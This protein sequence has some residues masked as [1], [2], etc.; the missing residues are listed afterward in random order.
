MQ[1]AG[2]KGA[3]APRVAGSPLAVIEA[4]LAPV[5]GRRL[6]DVG[7]GRG[8]LARHLVARGARV[9]GVD[10]LGAAVAEARA[11]VPEAE[12]LE[13]GAEALPF[14]AGSFD[15]A[16]LLNSLHHVPLPLMAAALDAVLRVSAGPVLVIEPLAEGPFFEAMR[17]VEDETDLRAAAQAAIARHVSEGRAAIVREHTFDDVRRFPDVDA[18]LAKIV[19]VDPGRAAAAARLR[20]AVEARMAQWGTRD[21]DGIRLDQPHRAVLLCRPAGL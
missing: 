21:G 19:A 1:Q 2:Q 14:A 20:G 13:T 6:L 17:P 16:V 11:G 15:G 3:G 10:P 18:F 5:E 9:C 8:A 12:F 7:C 4:W